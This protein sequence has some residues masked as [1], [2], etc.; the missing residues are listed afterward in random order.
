MQPTAGKNQQTQSTG[1]PAQRKR[2]ATQQETVPEKHRKE[3]TREQLSSEQA[4]LHFIRCW[5]S[6][7]PTAHT[8]PSH[9]IRHLSPIHTQK[10][11]EER[12]AYL[13]QAHDQEE[14]EEEREKE[15]DGKERPKMH[16]SKTNQERI[17][18]TL[19]RQR[20]KHPQQ[21]ENTPS[22][23]T[24]IH[25]DEKTKQRKE[26]KRTGE[27]ADPNKHGTMMHTAP[28]KTK[29]IIAHEKE[30]KRTCTTRQKK[31][32]P[33]ERRNQTKTGEKGKRKPPMQKKEKQHEGRHAKKKYKRKAS[34]LPSKNKKQKHKERKE[35]HTQTDRYPFSIILLILHTN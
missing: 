22:I 30:T 35:Q 32:T 34:H 29:G 27:K 19:T 15:R 1:R 5:I 6:T 20:T 12:N 24:S 23:H 26:R 25:P 13:I 8:T 17:S 31:Q 9:P 10:Q 11:K 3:G 14:E 21:R 7:M 2:I 18:P 33:E 16:R 28:T 4:F